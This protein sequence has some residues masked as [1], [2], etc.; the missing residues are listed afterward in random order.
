MENDFQ[1]LS[2]SLALLIQSSSWP[3]AIKVQLSAPLLTN[4]E[5]WGNWLSPRGLSFP[6]GTMDKIIRSW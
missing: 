2:A 6:I 4:H 5:A 3:Q 1:D